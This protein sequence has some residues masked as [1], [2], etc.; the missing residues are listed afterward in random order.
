[1]LMKENFGIKLMY[2]LSPNPRST[3]GE[4][5][6]LFWYTISLGVGICITVCDISSTRY[7][8]FTNLPGHD[9]R[10]LDHAAG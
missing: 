5:D 1:M 3:Q 8:I 4:G 6:I 2:V 7:L 9:H 10:L